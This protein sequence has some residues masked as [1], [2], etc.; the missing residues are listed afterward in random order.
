MTE[1]PEGRIT[2][3]KIQADELQI[4]LGEPIAGKTS[5]PTEA[6]IVKPNQN[7]S[8]LI[9]YHTAAQSY[10]IILWWIMVFLAMLTALNLFSTIIICGPMLFANVTRIYVPSFLCSNQ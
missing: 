6:K 1:L 3:G 2:A 4:Q 9:P 7:R 8:Q 10:H 5:T